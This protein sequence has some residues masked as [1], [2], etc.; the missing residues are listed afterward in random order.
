MPSARA[1]AHR[2]VAAAALAATLALASGC[3]DFMRLCASG[4]CDDAGAGEPA[5]AD[6]AAPQSGDLAGLDLAGVDLAAPGPDLATPTPGPDLGPPDLAPADL[7]PCGG[8]CA[9]SECMDG[10]RCVVTLATPAT[11]ELLRVDADGLYWITVAGTGNGMTSGVAADLDGNVKAT[12]FSGLTQ[13]SGFVVNGNTAW[14]I[15]QGHCLQAVDG[16]IYTGPKG[17]GSNATPLLG[18]LDCPTT[19]ATNG[20][21][22]FWTKGGAADGVIRMLPAGGGTVQTLSTGANAVGYIFADAQ[23]VYY[24]G[25]LNG[26][27]PNGVVVR[28]PLAGGADLS[29]TMVWGPG[30]IAFD[31]SNLYWA[32]TGAGA[33][34]K[35]LPF[36]G[37]TP[38]MVCSLSTNVNSG[39]TDGAY[40]YW[41]TLDRRV[42]AAP[43]GGGGPVTTLY[44]ESRPGQVS[45]IAVDA[46]YVYWTFLDPTTIGS[47]G[48]VMRTDKL[49]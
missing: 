49:P 41:T 16:T 13:V 5:T 2:P 44:T 36:T 37:G 45:S 9:P 35:R 47:T 10:S 11:P 6:L 48:A 21:T 29:E 30:F 38:A 26:T 3:W 22:L 8:R 7:G 25:Y 42:Q 39:A 20:T 4:A 14:W 32:E 28:H 23:A 1:R 40:V 33:N 46:R 15:D 12:V 27:A 19:L 17:G 43:V 34:V 24:G 18:A 31:A